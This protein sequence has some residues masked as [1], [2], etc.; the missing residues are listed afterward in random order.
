MHHCMLGA[1]SAGDIISTWMREPSP[2]Q[3]RDVRPKG[4]NARP[5]VMY[6]KAVSLLTCPKLDLEVFQ[7]T[8]TSVW[9]KCSRRMTVS[10]SFNITNKR[11]Q[12]CWTAQMAWG[13]ILSS[14]SFNNFAGSGKSLL[15]VEGSWNLFLVYYHDTQ[16]N[17]YYRKTDQPLCSE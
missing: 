3:S 16:H 6:G 11:W 1:N 4:R 10:V 7:I 5:L 13:T 2:E 12:P 15:A 17:R 8:R 14:A 9:G